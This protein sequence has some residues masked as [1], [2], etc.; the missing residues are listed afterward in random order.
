MFLA[1]VNDAYSEVK[2]EMSRQK[3]E[4]EMIDFF[5]KVKHSCLLLCDVD[6]NKCTSFERWKCV[7]LASFDII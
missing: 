2:S 7:S 3:H 4:F 5:K 6:I 1:I